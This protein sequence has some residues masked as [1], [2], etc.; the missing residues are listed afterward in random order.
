MDRPTSI[1]VA[2]TAWILAAVAITVYMVRRGHRPSR[3]AGLAFLLGPFAIVPAA[4]ARIRAGGV[5]ARTLRRGVP[6]S[7]ELAVL[8]GIDGSSEARRALL[9]ALE[10][11]GTGIGRLTLAAVLDFESARGRNVEDD[12]EQ[13]A[14]NLEDA[15]RFV[16]ERSVIEPSTVLLA[17]A[18]AEALLER[19]E[20][21]GDDLIVVGSHVPEEPDWLLGDTAAA[22]SAQN[23]IRVMVVPDDG[24]TAR[25]ASSG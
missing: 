17:G 22:L 21:H 7:G 12:R 14:R 4:W 15:A 23:S 9:E 25:A 6:G 3:W 2:V 1:D 5:R 8:V 13:A 19:A 24:D 11:L 20:T 16:R 18:P 10:T